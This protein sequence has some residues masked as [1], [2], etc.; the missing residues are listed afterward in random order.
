MQNLCFKEISGD[1]GQHTIDDILQ[2]SNYLEEFAGN[3]GLL[4]I[5]DDLV[6]CVMF[7]I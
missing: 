4:L 2:G 1:T 5:L 6:Y 7:I 3:G